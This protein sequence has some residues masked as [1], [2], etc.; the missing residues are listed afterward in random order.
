MSPTGHNV[1]YAELPE[2]VRRM[3]ERDGEIEFTPPSFERWIG[4]L[5]M[6]RTLSSLVAFSLVWLMTYTS[7]GSWENATVHG[8]VAAI[9]FHFFAWTAGLFLFGELYDAE[10]KRAR[11]ALEE[12]ER[13]R[14]RRIEEYYRERLR[15]QRAVGADGV[16]PIP[17]GTVPALGGDPL[18]VV[19][20]YHPMTED[21]TSRL[22]A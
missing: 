4:R 1:D 17:G 8:L 7:N 3:I 15:A 5:Q 16:E 14:A 18:T 6:L 22:A 10:V 13:E 9:A 21:V 20:G 19:E 11:R 2:H 12:R